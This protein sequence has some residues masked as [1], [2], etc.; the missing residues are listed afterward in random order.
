[1]CAVRGKHQYIG[2]IFRKTAHTR[3]LPQHPFAPIA[4]DGVTQAFGSNKC[5]PAV[6]VLVTLKHGYAHKRAS[7]PSSAREDPL[8]ILLGLDGLHRGALV[9]DGKA[10]AALRATARENL[11]AAL[12]GHAGA[13]AVGLGT[14]PL[15]WLVGALHVFLLNNMV[16]GTSPWTF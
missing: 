2:P 10:L 11:T 9:R 8:K 16:R 14:L 5:H 12:G 13:E 15:V 4:K 7:I 6:D 3:G 1:M